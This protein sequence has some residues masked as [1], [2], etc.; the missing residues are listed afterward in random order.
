MDGLTRN[1]TPID[2]FLLKIALKRYP[3]IQKAISAVIHLE[4][5]PK[6]LDL[7]QNE[8]GW[9]L[10]YALGSLVHA[11]RHSGSHTASDAV[12]KIK[13]HWEFHIAP[14]LAALLRV[15]TFDASRTQNATEIIEHALIVIPQL[16]TCNARTTGGFEPTDGSHWM[17]EQAMYLRPLLIRL[18]FNLLHERHRETRNWTL[19]LSYYGNGLYSR[20]MR[21]FSDPS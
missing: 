12:G 8:P 7:T 4:K 21:R 5:Q 1:Q 14:W 13:A 6:G 20:F 18:W 9:T 2:P 19:S 15:I 17:H 10:I 16:I 3:T 11:M